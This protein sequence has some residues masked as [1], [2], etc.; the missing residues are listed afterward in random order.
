MVRAQLQLLCTK[1]VSHMELEESRDTVQ[2]ACAPTIAES[3][4]D[5]ASTSHQPDLDRII[6][7]DTEV[8]S[9]PICSIQVTDNDRALECSNCQ[10]WL[11]ADCIGISSK[12]Y[13]D[14]VSDI[15]KN[16]VCHTCHILADNHITI[17]VRDVSGSQ[18]PTAATASPTLTPRTTLPAMSPHSVVA[19]TSAQTSSGY[20]TTTTT[21]S[22]RTTATVISAQVNST[23]MA[24]SLARTRPSRSSSMNTVPLVPVVRYVPKSVNGTPG[25]A[26]VVEPIRPQIANG[27]LSPSLTSTVTHH[28]TMPYPTALSTTSSH[29]TTAHS[30]GSSILSPTPTAPR[31]PSGFSTHNLPLRPLGPTAQPYSTRESFHQTTLS[32]ESAR[33]ANVT[34]ELAPVH[35]ESTRKIKQLEKKLVDMKLAKEH[36]EAQASTARAYIATLENLLSQKDDSLRLHRQQIASLNSEL[37]KSQ[38]QGTPWPTN[39]NVSGQASSAHH[40][41]VPQHIPAPNNDS[42]TTLQQQHHQLSIS[43]LQVQKDLITAQRDAAMFQLQLQ[44]EALEFSRLNTS[45]SHTTCNNNRRD[46]N[47]ERVT[48]QSTH[49]TK[50]RRR[51]DRQHHPPGRGH[52]PHPSYPLHHYSA[53]H[54]P[55]PTQH[56]VPMAPH[57]SPPSPSQTFGKQVDLAV[58]PR[59]IRESTL[60]TDVQPQN[61]RSIS[62]DHMVSPAFCYSDLSDRRHPLTPTS[63][64][65]AVCDDM[66][67]PALNMLKVSH[68]LYVDLPEMGL[69]QLSPSYPSPSPRDIGATVFQAAAHFLPHASLPRPKSL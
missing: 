34:S 39:R 31:N 44:R 47:A 43:S 7:A 45:M 46:V 59:L 65:G 54:L 1:K 64:P 2:H 21:L 53:T 20:C 8:D 9:C 3:F 63:P 33:P 49:G 19:I 11:H 52:Q 37:L 42:T 10:C 15:T 66:Q 56:H 28:S 4:L 5:S 61:R 40:A 12:E 57:V 18:L 50:N 48:S 14:H 41:P 68:P 35:A 22:T 51:K 58:P 30:R 25:M 38:Q 62:L 24:S 17:N 6:D 13:S 69:K 26:T 55:N 32:C 36:A 67:N 16:F 27:T 29:T 60:L 23:T